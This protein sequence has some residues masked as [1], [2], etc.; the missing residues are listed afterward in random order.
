L[1]SFVFVRVVCVFCD[2]TRTDARDC[3]FA[4]V[5]STNKTMRLLLLLLQQ[6][7]QLLLMAIINVY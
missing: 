3:V 7:K 2:L 4:L 1:Y 6:T 5:I